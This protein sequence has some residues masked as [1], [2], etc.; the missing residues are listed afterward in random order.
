MPPAR[1]KQR[2]G[3]ESCGGEGGGGVP[4]G[5]PLVDEEL[6]GEEVVPKVE[7]R[8]VKCHSG[9]YVCAV[10][11]ESERE[12]AEEERGDGRGD[13]GGEEQDEGSRD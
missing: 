12:G 13:D 7:G 4:A 11:P 6:E 3:E 5:D 1:E 9:G 2:G 10:H 8:D